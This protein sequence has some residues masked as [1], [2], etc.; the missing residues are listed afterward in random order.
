MDETP[1][2]LEPQALESLR[3]TR[4]WIY[5][6]AILMTVLCVILAIVL[7]A[8]VLGF[9]A[10]PQRAHL[11]VG[12]GIGGL[13]VGTPLAAV[14]YGYGMALSDV[15]EA[16]GEA[17]TR[18]IERACVRQRTLW[19]VTAVVFGLSALIAIFQTLNLFLF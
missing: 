17:L 9:G 18:A 1:L 8:G 6:F 14:Q 7:V 2:I 5:L 11:M 10:D 19:I 3:R 13:I 16:R 15:V 4:P 12:A